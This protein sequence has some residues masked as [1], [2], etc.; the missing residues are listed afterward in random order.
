[1]PM[2]SALTS[3]FE[4]LKTTKSL[5]I[6]FS[7]CDPHFDFSLLRNFLLLFLFIRQSSSHS[8]HSSFFIC[9]GFFFNM[10]HLL[11]ILLSVL[12]LRSSYT[13]NKTLHYVGKKNVSII[14]C[15]IIPIYFIVSI[16]YLAH[17]FNLY[18]LLSLRFMIFIMII[19]ISLVFKKVW[20]IIPIKN[21]SIHSYINEMSILGFTRCWNIC[22][23]IWFNMLIVG[24]FNMWYHILFLTSGFTKTSFIPTGVWF[25]HS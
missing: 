8:F 18:I 24:L 4:L 14:I 21:M 19:L 2:A 13:S 23:S 17:N 12:V 25:T 20:V 1:M 22:F 7:F 10:H 3:N 9:F 15:F 6:F 16:R 5:L 11:N